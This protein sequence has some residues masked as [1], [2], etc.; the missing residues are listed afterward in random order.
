MNTLEPGK[1]YT[2]RA[3]Y[4]TGYYVDKGFTLPRKVFTGEP[5]LLV[6]RGEFYSD[7]YRAPHNS[8]HFFYFLFKEEMLRFSV[9][10]LRE[11]TDWMEWESLDDARKA[12]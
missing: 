1:L 9:D 10:L 5:L 2:P 11:E 3:Q 12:L 4:L 6:K 8:G 7:G